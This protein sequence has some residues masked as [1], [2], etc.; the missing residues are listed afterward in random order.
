MPASFPSIYSFS[1]LLFNRKSFPIMRFFRVFVH[2]TIH[3]FL[4]GNYELIVWENVY[5]AIPSHILLALRL[6]LD[7]TMNIHPWRRFTCDILNLKDDYKISIF[8]LLPNVC[9]GFG[10]DFMHAISNMSNQIQPLVTFL[11]KWCLKITC[12]LETCRA[13]RRIYLSVSALC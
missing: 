5:T 11:C 6:Y 2:A 10:W 3:M 8:F 4:W 7:L 13:K 1:V 9:D 12:P